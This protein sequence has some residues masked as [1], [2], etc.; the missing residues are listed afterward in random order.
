MTA[1]DSVSPPFPP[2]IVTDD[3]AVAASPHESTISFNCLRNA[4]TPTFILDC[5]ISLRVSPSKG[6]RCK[7]SI[8]GNKSFPVDDV[9]TFDFFLGRLPALL[10]VLPFFGFG[11][12]STTCTFS[13][14]VLSLNHRAN[15]KS[16]PACMNILIRAGNISLRGRT[17]FGLIRST[18]TTLTFALLF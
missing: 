2:S 8:M 9:I 7:N 6:I 10:V 17:N 4:R 1:D 3:S 5:R 16:P 11:I 12:A 13:N 18:T 15:S 14:V